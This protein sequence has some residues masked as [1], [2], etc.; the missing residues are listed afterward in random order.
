[1]AAYALVQQAGEQKGDADA[2]HDADDRED[3]G[4]AQRF[5]EEFLAQQFL[6]ITQT[7]EFGRLQD[8]PLGEAQHKGEDERG[9]G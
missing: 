9:R 3:R 6:E 5:P 7:N 8:A 2:Q 1:M 4:D